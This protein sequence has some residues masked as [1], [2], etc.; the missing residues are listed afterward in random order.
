MS[1]R[2]MPFGKYRGQAL[3]TI[4]DDYLDWLMSLDLREPLATS[5]EDEWNLRHAK[6]SPLTPASMLAA[7]EV[8]R[9]GFKQAARSRHPDAGGSHEAMLEL[10]DAV[11]FLTAAVAEARLAR[12]AKK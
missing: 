12:E 8:I 10:N 3:S 7:R 6:G 11:I 9:L 4:P 2:T 1:V 5:V